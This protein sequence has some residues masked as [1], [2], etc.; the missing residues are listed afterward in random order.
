MEDLRKLLWDRLLGEWAVIKAAP[1]ACALL[2]LFGAYFGFQLSSWRNDGVIQNLDSA[3][4]TKDA[5]IASLREKLDNA[6]KAPAQ[7]NVAREPDA[8]YQLGRKVGDA[9]GIELQLSNGLVFFRAIVANATFNASSEFEFRDMVLKIVGMDASGAE[10]SMRV[11]Q[12]QSF[13]G[14]KALIVRR[15]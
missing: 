9:T 8:I 10:A 7:Q 4:K 15:V 1:S 14:V 5:V 3:G 13:S 12:Q 2:V 6:G 11:I